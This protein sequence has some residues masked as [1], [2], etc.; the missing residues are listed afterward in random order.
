MSLKIDA[1]KAENRIYEFIKQTEGLLELSYDEG[2]EEKKQME[3]KLSSFAETAFTDGEKKKNKLYSSVGVISTTERSPKR[4]QKD[5]EDELKRKLRNLKAWKEEIELEESSKEEREKVDKLKEK[6]EEEKLEAERREQ[7]VEQKH[8][9]ALI[10]FLDMQRNRIKEM[11][12]TSKEIT[13][14]K[15]GIEDIKELLKKNLEQKEGEEQ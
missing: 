7:V 2:K 9:G 4:K 11:E 14:I 13:E 12:E 1:E 10:E 3:T 8:N 6:V 15:K 5:Y